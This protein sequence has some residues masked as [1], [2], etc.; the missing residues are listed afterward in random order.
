M[1][2]PLGHCHMFGLAQEFNPPLCI[3]KQILNSQWW[4]Q[5]VVRRGEHWNL[6]EQPPASRVLQS[7]LC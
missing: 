1:E 7:L 4:L 2:G 5:G 6:S 3:G